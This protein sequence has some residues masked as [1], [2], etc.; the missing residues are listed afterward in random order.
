MYDRLKAN[1]TEDINSVEPSKHPQPIRMG[2][3]SR[4]FLF[5]HLQF[6]NC[7]ACR[8]EAKIAAI[9][10]RSIQNNSLKV[11]SKKHENISKILIAWRTKRLKFHAFSLVDF[12]Y[13]IPLR[14]Y[15]QNKRNNEP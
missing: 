13:G 9:Q 3:I 6:S 8:Y 1:N 15:K 14:T 5:N 12:T 10:M 7:M 2:D 11:Q 4:A